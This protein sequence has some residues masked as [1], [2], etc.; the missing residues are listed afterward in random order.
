MSLPELQ[1]IQTAQQASFS[2]DQAGVTGPERFSNVHAEYAWAQTEA[3]LFDL[4]HHGCL[5]LRGADRRK[6]LHNFCTQDIKGLADGQVA[7][8]ILTTLQGKVFDHVL[9][10]AAGDAVRVELASG[11]T[12]RLRA[13]LDRYLITEDVELVDRSQELAS[14]YLAGPESVPLLQRLTGQADAEWP[15]GTVRELTIEGTTVEFV[16]HEFLG[17]PGGLLRVPRTAAAAVWTCLTE[18]GLHPAGHLVYH[19]LRIEAGWPLWGVD[20]TDQ[21]LAQEAARTTQA[22]SFTKGCY[23]G[24]EPIARIDALGHVNQELRGVHCLGGAVP[25]VG[26][27]LYLAMGQKDVGRVTSSALSPRDDTPVALVF[28]KR[29]ALTP[30]QSVLLQAGTEFTPGTVYWPSRPQ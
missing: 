21:N 7:E 18:H 3:V 14:L 30:G 29:N 24:Q 6:F 22:I 11:Q 27:N 25:A 1:T 8:A 10:T 20:L 9:V 19:A 13:H 23:L 2:V 26:A 28:L 15:V 5:E 17:V 4:T 16:R 12:E